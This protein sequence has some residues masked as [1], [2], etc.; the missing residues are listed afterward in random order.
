MRVVVALTLVMMVAEI[1]AGSI[2]GSMALLAD[3]WHM[4]TH[5]GALS[6]SALAYAYARRR[7][8]DPRF[9]FGTG[10][11]GDLAGFT[12]AVLLAVVACAIGWEGVVRWFE[13][14]AIHFDEAI[15]VAVLGLFVNLASA[16]LLDHGDAGEGEHGHEREHGPEHEREPAREHGHDHN[17]RSAYLHV[18]ADALTSVFAIVALVAGKYLEWAWMDPL[19]GIVGAVVI[20]RWSWGLVRATGAVLVDA[21]PDPALVAAIRERVEREGDVLCDLHVWRVGPGHVAA[22][23]SIASDTPREPSEYK[24]RLTELAPLAHVTVEVHRRR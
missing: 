3:G 16:W 21:T 17:L 5:A 20:L 15:W 4:A 11:V 1:V 22:I 18:L 23:V 10:K 13:P 12:S 7:A 24:R 14:R 8:D 2:F 9:A 6:I 19:C